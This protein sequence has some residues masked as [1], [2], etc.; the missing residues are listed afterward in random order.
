MYIYSL[1][2]FTIRYLMYLISINCICIFFLFPGND[3]KRLM[4]YAQISWRPHFSYLFVSAYTLSVIVLYKVLSNLA[5]YF[6]VPSENQ[7]ECLLEIISQNM[8]MNHFVWCIIHMY[9]CM[10]FRRPCWHSWW[11]FWLY[12]FSFFIS[13]CV[14]FSKTSVK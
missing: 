10:C 6:Y 9:I 3:Y 7:V 4:L 5:L 1:Y 11:Y 14:L 2:S 12:V 13:F 8:W